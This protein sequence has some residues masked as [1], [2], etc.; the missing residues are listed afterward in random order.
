MNI[1]FYRVDVLIQSI[2]D[3]TGTR[4]INGSQ[5]C[6]RQ[7]LFIVEHI[8]LYIAERENGEY[9]ILVTSYQT[10]SANKHTLLVI[11]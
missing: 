11:L 8:N 4:F 3:E 1:M 6:S 9:G 5:S 2:K 7:T 10:Y